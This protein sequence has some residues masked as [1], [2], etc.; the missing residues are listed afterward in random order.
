MKKLIVLLCMIATPLAL[1]ACSGSSASTTSDEEATEQNLEEDD[2]AQSAEDAEETAK[3]TT[4]SAKQAADASDESKHKGA[5]SCPA[6]VE[7]VSAEAKKSKGKV[8]LAMMA[9]G[10]NT[11]DLR[12]R[13]QMMVQHHNKMHERH[14]AKDKGTD[15][16]MGKEKGMAKG[17]DKGMQRGKKDKKGHHAMGMATATYEETEGGAMIH[18]T[19]ADEAHMAGLESEVGEHA[20]WINEGE[21]PRQKMHEKKAH[22]KH[23]KG[24]SAAEGKTESGD[25]DAE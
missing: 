17:K 2:S 23:K 3:E 21:C 11:A 18:F 25:E 1:T 13:A 24:K 8:S 12:K 5:E 9:P 16:A 4:D 6:M 20:R 19:P 10:E 22:K 7:G 14:M 15:K